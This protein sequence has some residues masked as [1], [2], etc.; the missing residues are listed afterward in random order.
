MNGASSYIGSDRGAL[1]VDTTGVACPAGGA[2]GD[3]VDDDD[4]DDD[5]G[6]HTGSEH[7]RVTSSRIDLAHRQASRHNRARQSQTQ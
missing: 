3:T 4:D 6:E 1:P 5:W 7:S 2:L